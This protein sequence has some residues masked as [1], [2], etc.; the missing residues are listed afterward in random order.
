MSLSKS[1]LA[2]LSQFGFTQFSDSEANEEHHVAQWLI[3]VLQTLKDD[4]R[5]QIRTTGNVQLI[6]A[7]TA[8][9]FT[10]I[11]INNADGDASLVL[12][13]Q[14]L[15]EYDIHESKITAVHANDLTKFNFTYKNN[16][17]ELE[18]EL[19]MFIEEDFEQVDNGTS[20]IDIFFTDPEW[21]KSLNDL[22]FYRPN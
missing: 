3:S 11:E 5:D 6:N 2:L 14:F 18:D 13:G 20:I 10:Y 17:T 9:L 7:T 22:V 4:I 1:N 15:I 19:A 8:M 16:S 12:S 21:L